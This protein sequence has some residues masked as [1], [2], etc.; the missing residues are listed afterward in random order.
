VNALIDA[1]IG[2]S[3]TVLA[4]LLLVLLA[5]AVS[6]A[7]IPKESDPDIDIPIIYVSMSHEGI[8]PAD[9]ERLLVRPM[10]E[11][12]RGIDGVKE[13][14]ST[15]SE[16]HASV[17]LEFDA[18]FDADQAMLDVR[19]KVDLV[20]PELPEDT[21]EPTVNEVNV[22][23]FPVLTVTLSGDVPERA[24][25]KIARDLK[26]NVEALP[27]VLSAEIAGDREELLEIAIDPARLE[28][29]GLTQQELINAVALNNRLVAAGALDTGAGRF[30]VKVPGLLETAK[31]VLDLPLKASGDAVV[32]LKDV[33]TIRRTFKDP[34]TFAR[35]NGQPALTLEVKKR[36]GVNIIETIDQVRAVVG[37]MR[38]GWPGALQIGFIQDKSQDIRQM[39]GDLQN[40]VLSAILLV[41]V[42]VVAALGLRTAGLVGLAIPSS[43][44]FGI[45]VL[46]SLDL[47][48]NIVV[49]FSLILAVGMLVDGAIVVTEYADRK[50][51]EGLH[52]RDAYAL[53]AKRMAWPIIAS[54]ATTLAAFMPLIFW[55]GVVGE[56]MKYLPLT[57]IV[58]LSGSLI[59]ALIFVPTLGGLI[60]KPGAADPRTMKALAA[61]EGGDV[62][63]LPGLTGVYARVLSVAVRHPVKIVLVAVAMLVGVQTFYATHGN[64]VE[65]FPDVE[66]EQGLIYVHARGNLSTVEKDKLVKEVEARILDLPGLETVYARTGNLGQGN[67]IAEDVVGTIFIEFA[68]W[69]TRP[70][71]SQLMNEMRARTAGLAGIHVETRKPE[72]GPPQG[73]DIQI[74]LRSRAPERIDPV[75]DTIRA[76]LEGM[77]T[78]LDVEDSRPLPG[79]QWSVRVDRAQAGRF[80][81][82]VT[83]VGNLVQLVTNGV[84]LGEY[85]PDDADDEIDIR[86]RFPLDERNIGQLDKLRVQTPQGLVPVTNFVERVPEPKTGTLNRTDGQR[87]IKIQANVQDGVLIDDQVQ[88]IKAWLAR[89]QLD[90]AV[91]IT[92]KGADQ[93][94]AEAGAFLMKAFGVAL[95][96]MAIILVTQFNSFYH[97][98][99]ILT[100]VIMSTV[101]V[102]L[103]LIITGQVFGIVMTGIGVIALAGIVVNNN[104]VLIDTY[105][106]L[107]REM[108]PIEAVVRT[109]TQRLRPVMLTTITTICGL[110][111]MCLQV[112]ID[113][114]A[115]TVSI[116]APS[117]QW[118]VQLAT[119]VAFG[120]AFA[121]VLTLLVT[122]SMLALGARVTAWRQRRAERRAA[123]KAGKVVQDRRDPSVQPAE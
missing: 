13:M 84:K 4:V 40:N 75:V 117:T 37:E 19:E 86:V 78:L 42:V 98:F 18:G 31:D 66:P 27:G 102:V 17:L 62:R 34:T 69:D 45:L 52:R 55:P 95:F 107:A 64:G 58:T 83:Q 82:D 90:P 41:M 71:A 111:P 74:E 22:G 88:A 23:L 103:G 28:S 63:T 14:R 72:A 110:L 44:L 100:A 104:I 11:E 33:S 3:R 96:V 115:R 6:Y 73:K 112:N 24:L 30:A 106:R 51:S 26:D 57:L 21:D 123:R 10:E 94:Q 36:L 105:Q 32:T 35:V 60:G 12:L 46:H 20:K 59:V 80:G 2:R 91:S 39:L 122:P 68:D 89:Q 54:T 70:A 61:A 118:W 16:G 48:V 77:A 101:G 87:M 76:Y 15:A 5:G 67:D 119:A 56:F 50:M 65:F 85:R 109:G 38:P 81:A 25:L 114:F 47:T 79:I 113:F 29:F 7:T 9:A 108:D 92:F 8:S 93:E 49:L 53:A 121:T 99:L 116:G 1:A 97:A 43:F 120:L